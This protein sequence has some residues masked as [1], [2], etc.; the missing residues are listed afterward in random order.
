MNMDTQQYQNAPGNTMTE[1]IRFGQAF[2]YPFRKFSRIFNVLWAL[3]PIVGPLAVYG[4]SVWIAQK[5]IRGEYEQ[6]PKFNFS[7]NLKLG[8]FMFLKFIPFLIAISVIYTTL[9]FLGT[10]GGII[11]AILMFFVYPILMI[12]FMRHETV[13]ASFDIRVVKPVFTHIGD[14]LITVLK[15][16][17]LVLIFA[18]MLLIFIG[19]PALQFTQGIF[20][21]DFYRRRVSNKN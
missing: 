9:S 5:F 16:I 13:A 18:A 19:Y 21:A 15:S 20:L 3:V 7:K 10:V 17:V 8:F 11:T 2:A 6:L 14:Y 12:N 1:K 4:Y